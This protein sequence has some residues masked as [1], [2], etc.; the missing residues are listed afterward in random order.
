MTNVLIFFVGFILAIVIG[1]IFKINPGF[2]AIAL[3]FIITWIFLGAKGTSNSFISLFPVSL[4]WNYG[5]PI[6]FYAFAAANG[7][8]NSLGQHIIWKFRNAKWAVSLAILVVAAV[9]AVCGAGTSNTFIVAP[10]AWSIAIPAGLPI[11]LVPF[12]LWCGSFIGSFWPWTSNAALHIGLITQNVKG[13]NVEN[14]IWA[15]GAYYALFAIVIFVIAFFALKGW[16]TQAHADDSVITKPAP[17]TSQQKITLGIIFL[18]IALLLVPSILKTIMPKNAAFVWMASNL[19]IPVTS[20]IGISIL[21]ILNLGNLS[22]VFGKHVNWNVLWTITGMSMY[23]GL[24]NSL[25]VITTLGNALKTLPPVI[26][27]PAV[28]AIGAALSFVVS[29]SAVLP[30]LYAMVP[31]LAAAAHISPAAMVI[32]VAM[33]VGV[34]SFSPFSVGGATSLI[35]APPDV[36]GKLVVKMIVCAVA[37]ALFGVVLAFLGVFRIGL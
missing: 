27:A 4:F 6:I 32:T 24:A 19:S 3:G 22:E 36:A 14:T 34:T 17:F 31:A 25:G 28:V 33:G 12:A 8:L 26:I 20:A 10:L 5:M 13:I 1:Q 16:K 35:G 30:L 37:M 15:M 11:L 21:C 29:A 9:V 18:L 7:T 2:V 23:C